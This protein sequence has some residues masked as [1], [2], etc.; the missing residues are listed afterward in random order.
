MPQTYVIVVNLVHPRLSM[1]INNADE[2]ALNASV[3]QFKLVGKRN[4]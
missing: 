4:A 1:A 2:Q 3:S